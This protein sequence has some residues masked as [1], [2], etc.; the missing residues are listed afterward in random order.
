LSI[1]WAGSRRPAIA[2]AGGYAVHGRK[3]RGD[4]P[5]ADEAGLFDIGH[6]HGALP[7]ILLSSEPGFRLCPAL[8]E[9]PGHEPNPEDASDR[10]RRPETPGRGIGKSLDIS[11][12]PPLLGA[13]CVFARDEH[14]R[15][16]TCLMRSR[17]GTKVG[18]R[19]RSGARSTPYMPPLPGIERSVPQAAG[20]LQV[21]VQEGLVVRAGEGPP[22][23]CMTSASLRLCTRPS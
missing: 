21:L 19:R 3:D 9:I 14:F 15:T 7:R 13:L 2:F 11:P 1:Q 12:E 4:R 6:T 8:P 22:Y 5:W 17:E 20:R 23:V 18:W 10:P 16:R